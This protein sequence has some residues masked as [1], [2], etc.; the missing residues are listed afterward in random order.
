MRKKL[1]QA[2][3]LD[4]EKV[5]TLAQ[6]SFPGDLKPPFLSR[7]LL[8]DPLTSAL[9]T[10]LPA[11]AKA[12][13]QPSFL[14]SRS[15]HGCSRRSCWAV[16]PRAGSGLLQ[17]GGRARVPDGD[18]R[19]AGRVPGGAG[20]VGNPGGSREGRGSWAGG[21][22]WGRAPELSVCSAV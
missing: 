19:Q 6:T 7:A 22:G 11:S 18:S 1:G 17:P 2:R 21:R 13:S 3:G 8:L 20:G 10:L 4:A 9:E 12:R 16:A 14:R 5:C 15:P